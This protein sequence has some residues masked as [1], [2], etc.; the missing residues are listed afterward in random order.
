[1]NQMEYFIKLE[2]LKNCKTLKELENFI[3]ENIFHI[4]DSYNFKNNIPKRIFYYKLLVLAHKLFT[5]RSKKELPDFL[6]NRL[7]NTQ[8]DILN[9]FL[10]KHKEEI[11][12]FAYSYEDFMDVFE[13]NTKLIFLGGTEQLIIFD[14]LIGENPLPFS[15]DFNIYLSAFDNVTT[16]GSISDKKY[17]AVLRLNQTFNPQ[18]T[19]SVLLKCLE[20]YLQNCRGAYSVGEIQ[21]FITLLEQQITALK[22]LKNVNG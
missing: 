15:M 12:N 2:Y 22:T 6:L 21:E 9:L 19:R 20:S 18:K 1:M 17:L 14:E 3:R 13:F 11:P 5:T 16:F 4:K 8:K 7:K 10:D